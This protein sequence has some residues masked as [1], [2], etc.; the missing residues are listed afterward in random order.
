[1][2]DKIYKPF[3]V[4][5]DVGFHIQ[6]SQTG[7]FHSIRQGKRIESGGMQIKKIDGKTRENWD[8]FSNRLYN[9]LE[10]W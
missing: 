1:M 7:A 4:Y 9:R 10:V 8:L 3:K 2:A 6:H 5:G